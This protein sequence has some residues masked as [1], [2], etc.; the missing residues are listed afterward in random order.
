MSIQVKILLKLIYYNR[1]INYC[2]HLMVVQLN[3]LTDNQITK[4]KGTVL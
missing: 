1:I 3:Y 2:V 4:I